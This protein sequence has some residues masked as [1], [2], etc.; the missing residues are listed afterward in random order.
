MINLETPQNLWRKLSLTLNYILN[1]VH[2]ENTS[3]CA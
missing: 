2:N 1:K 3:V